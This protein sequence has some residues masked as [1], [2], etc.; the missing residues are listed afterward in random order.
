MAIYDFFLSRNSAAS[1]VSNYV[2]HAG[3]L[4]YDS[5]DGLFRLS[6]GV[7]PGGKILSNLAVASVSVTAPILPMPG[8]L[9]YNPNTKE[10][11]AYYNGQF[12]GTINPATPTVLGGIKAGPG[13]VVA[14]DGTLSLDSTGIP[15]NFGDFYATTE[16]DPPYGASLSSIQ[17]N[18][19]INIVSNGTGT[20]NI[21]GNLSVY[22][23]D[24]T[25]SG[26]MSNHPVLSINR[27]GQTQI[28]VP[29]VDP[30]EGA[31]AI[32][33]EPTDT[34][35]P[36]KQPG[37]ML[38]VTG[39]APVGV[40]NYASRI[41]NDGQNNFAAFVG[42]RFN[43]NTSVPTAVKNN[44]V[45]LRLSAVGY[46]ATTM[47]DFG[48]G[49]ISFV[50]AE[51]FTDVAQGGRIEF[52]TNPIGSNVLTLVGSVTNASGISATK[53]TGNITGNVTG[54]ISGTTGTFTGNVSANYLKGNV[55]L[56]AG[57]ATVA[58]LQFTSGT[59]LTTPL[60]GAFEYDGSLFYG[61][62]QDAQR[63]IIPNQQWYVT[64]ADR[65]LTYTNMT[66]Q[67]VFAYAP[68]VTSGKR[69]YFRIKFIVTRSAG[70]NTT[71]LTLAWNGGA[72]LTRVSYTVQSKIGATGTVGTE[73]MVEYVTTSNFS[74]PVP[75]SATSNAPST[76]TVIITGFVGV[77]TGGT[78]D[79]RISWEG[80]TAPGT[81]TV[82][83]GSNFY[84]YPIGDSGSNPTIIGNWSAT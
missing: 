4:F 44:D 72:G 22:K 26:A 52:Y 53:F 82:S 84:L 36:P 81:V 24:S 6:D 25:V 45:L 54:N 78:F 67:S 30:Y 40:T 38:H 7:T 27:D 68:N 28:L 57:T 61:T 15:F 3:R 8:E 20:I 77:N 55:E 14:A 73:N 35:V 34:Q 75:I 50:A 48:S 13:V 11:W 47:P 46:G 51:D 16:S 83:A 76:T 43:G 56:P 69:Y 71:A 21:I 32:I 31:V 74:T 65:T 49:R 5:A 29:T 42:R 9:W 1:N 17:P 62:P 12:R 19:D 41:Y 39:L 64:V 58:P 23:P 60:A 18:Q 37:V 70:T 59:N 79:P 66:A 10:L 33:G 80:S 2:G 63:G